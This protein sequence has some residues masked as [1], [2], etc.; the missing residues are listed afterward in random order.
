MRTVV[1]YPPQE[2][3]YDSEE[4]DD[5]MERAEREAERKYEAW[6]E[7]Q[8]LIAEYKREKRRD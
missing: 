1:V 3:E 2:E 5:W 8:E 7:R 6:V 4:H